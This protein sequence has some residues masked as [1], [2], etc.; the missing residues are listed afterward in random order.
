MKLKDVP[1]ELDFYWQGNRYRQFFRPKNPEGEF[2]VVCYQPTQGEYV[3]MP[4]G[5]DVKPVVR[6]KKV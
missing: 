2:K 5:R 3:E 4:S 6:A 1:Y